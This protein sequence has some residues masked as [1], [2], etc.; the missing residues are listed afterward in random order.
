MYHRAKPSKLTAWRVGQALRR[1]IGRAPWGFTRDHRRLNR[2]R[3]SHRPCRFAWP[4]GS[5]SITCSEPEDRRQADSLASNRRCSS[6]TNTGKIGRPGLA[7]IQQ[8]SRLSRKLPCRSGRWRD[9]R[10]RFD[11]ESRYRRLPA[12]NWPKGR[13]RLWD[14][15]QRH[16]LFP[17]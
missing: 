10:R 5:P 16:P 14:L 1:S 11:D 13:N 9:R 8:A 6:A 4:N 7:G 3:S 17:P 2:T 12:R 15:P